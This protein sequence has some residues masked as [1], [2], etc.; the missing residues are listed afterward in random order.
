MRSPTL[1]KAVGA[2]VGGLV[3]G[4]N[5]RMAPQSTLRSLVA[6]S[7]IRFARDDAGQALRHYVAA[8]IAATVVAVIL[9]TLLAER[10]YHEFAGAFAP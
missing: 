1:P 10:I 3:L 6:E 7:A 8:V 2:V 9:C 4:Y 5:V